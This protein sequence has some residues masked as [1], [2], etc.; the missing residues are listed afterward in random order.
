MS[1]DQ[2]LETT[3]NR[4][5]RLM[6]DRESSPAST[7][8]SA[9]MENL[10]RG[11][12]RFRYLAREKAMLEIIEKTPVG[13]CITDETGIFQYVNPAYCRLYGYSSDELVGRHFTLVVPPVNQ[14]LMKDLHDR[15]MRQEY[16]LQGE[17][18]V[19]RRD[20]TPLNILATAAYTM[21]D[22]GRAKK[23]TF[24]TDITRRK[25]AERQFQATLERLSEEI[26]QRQEVERIKEDVARIMRHDLRNSLSA[27]IGL[28]RILR[29]TE[30][31]ARQKEMVGVMGQAADNML[32]IINNSL[33]MVQMEE[34]LYEPDYQSIDLLEMLRDVTAQLQELSHRHRV[35]IS[36]TV[37]GKP[38]AV[39][40]V[41]PLDGERA[42]LENLFMNLVKNAV[43]AS[44][45]ESTVRIDVSES[46]GEN[47]RITI[48]N[49]G[50]IPADIRPRFLEKYATS[51]KKGGLGLGVYSAR[52]IARA[53]RGDIDYATHDVS[54]TTLTIRLPRRQAT[55]E[56]HS[57]PRLP[58]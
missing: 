3:L 52:L 37:T 11:L 12:R 50:A 27:L 54:G 16:E 6:E 42:Y 9:T 24:V 25:E 45:A 43:E 29:N 18:D 20:G 23:I 13:I 53:H 10:Q 48:H 58:W 51:G 44:P 15:F 35:A 57:V 14:D 30:L 2:E 39:G 8:I 32:R 55:R 7:D 31:N 1:Y 41:L 5:I 49:Q 46:P 22:E 4:L 34:G 21:D 26:R 19:V 17:W 28:S 33:A 47:Y 36:L 38:L 56:K 40:R